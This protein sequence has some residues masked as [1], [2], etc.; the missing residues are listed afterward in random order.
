MALRTDVEEIE[1]R[2]EADPS[3]AEFAM[4]AE[5]YRRAGRLDD[6]RRVAVAGLVARPDDAAGRIAL[7]LALLDLGETAAARYELERAMGSMAGGASESLFTP[8]DGEATYGGG[9]TNA[10]GAPAPPA[11]DSPA[12]VLASDV[13][14]LPD[15]E[16][17]AAEARADA[18]FGAAHALG[19]DAVGEDELEAAFAEAASVREEMRDANSIAAE[20]MIA[21]RLDEPE[22][23]PLE[24]VEALSAVELEPFQ[25]DD[26]A[27]APRFATATMARLLAEQGNP[28]AAERIRSRLAERAPEGP[29]GGRAIELDAASALG[30]A[31]PLRADAAEPEGGFAP[32]ADG[33]RRAQLLATLESWLANLQRGHA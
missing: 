14:S 30:L 33:A 6:A 27:V 28:A 2:V 1:R 22:G 18:P 10:G 3:S 20:A 26:A 4:L 19:A 17:V 31:S 21:G 16:A 32:A 24:D 7:G 13:E 23:F 15:I 12:R 9:I 11:S 5:L 29:V 25:I 8:A